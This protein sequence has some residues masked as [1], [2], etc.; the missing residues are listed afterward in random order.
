M[1]DPLSFAVA[2][3]DESL[4]KYEPKSLWECREPSPDQLKAL[5]GEGIETSLVKW[6]GQA[7]HLLNKIIQRRDR[8]LCSV[9]QMNWLKKHHIDATLMTA[10]EAKKHQRR[11]FANF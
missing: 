3:G 6:R 4:A 8:G 2:I 10:E 1:I 9:R 11:L 5:E 7:E